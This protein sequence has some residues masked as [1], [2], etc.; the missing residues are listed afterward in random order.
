MSCATSTACRSQI[1]HLPPPPLHA[2]QATPVT[3]PSRL[4][5]SP[6]TSPLLLQAC[7]SATGRASMS[8]CRSCS[9]WTS[10][11]S[12][13]TPCCR[14][15]CTGGWVGAER[16]RAG[17]WQAEVGRRGRGVGA[18][19]GAEGGKETVVCALGSTCCRKACTCVGRG[20]EVWDGGGGTAG[21]HAQVGDG[22]RGGNAGGWHAHAGGKGRAVGRRGFAA[23]RHEQ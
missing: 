15:A 12:R 9:T 5:P 10:R 8:C 16:D 7:A 22:Q 18:G 13:C 11:S 2:I 20:A 14:P 1:V 19:W 21:W 23:G 4:P 17:G 6:S 3:L